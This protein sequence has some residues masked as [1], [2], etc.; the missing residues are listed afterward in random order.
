MKKPYGI[1]IV[2][3]IC[4]SAKEMI[5]EH[6]TMRKIKVKANLVRLKKAA[7]KKESETRLWP[8]MKNKRPRTDGAVWV[9][10]VNDPLIPAIQKIEM[11][12]K[13]KM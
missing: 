3:K 2:E 5:T 12:N 4:K 6:K 7:K 10:S 1:W 11:E 13:Y 8:H 9:N